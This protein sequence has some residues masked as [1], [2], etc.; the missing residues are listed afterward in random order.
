MIWHALGTY[1]GP[2]RPLAFVMYA[3]EDK[4]RR[5]EDE[6]YRVYVAEQLRL[7]GEGKYLPSSL[8]DLLHPKED[9]DA[10]Q[11]IESVIERAGLEVIN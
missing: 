10:G 8:Y 5:D 6:A 1:R 7:H 9:F 2:M 3:A 11:V 4:R